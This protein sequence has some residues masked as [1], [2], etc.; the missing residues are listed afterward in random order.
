MAEIKHQ[1][2]KVMSS[3]HPW[4]WMWR[5]R[6]EIGREVQVIEQQEEGFSEE[7]TLHDTYRTLLITRELPVITLPLET[8]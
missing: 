6:H 3:I 1:W 8:L 4:R 2:L 5:I 7:D